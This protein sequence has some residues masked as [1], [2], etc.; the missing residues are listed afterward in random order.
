MELPYRTLVILKLHLNSNLNKNISTRRVKITFLIL[1]LLLLSPLLSYSESSADTETK[2]LDVGVI[3]PLTGD[4]SYWGSNPRK[5]LD[6]AIQDLE[7]GNKFK[8]KFHIE[9]DS[10]NARKAVSAFQKLTDIDK[11][12][13]VL[14]PVCSS[15][16]LAVAPLALIKDIPLIVFSEADSLSGLQNVFRLWAPNG[17]QAITLAKYA[18]RFNS[19][20]IL[21]VENAFGIDLANHVS[22]E[23]ERLGH[24]PVTYETYLPTNAGDLKTQLIKIRAKRPDALLFISYIQDGALLVKQAKNMGIAVPLLGPSTVNNNDFY[25]QL[26]PLANGIVLA[27]LPDSSSKEFRERWQKEFKEPWPGMQS[28]GSLFYD[29]VKI[30]ELAT[31]SGVETTKDWIDYLFKLKDFHGQSGKIE[32]DKIGDLKLEHVLFQ[33]EDGKAIVLNK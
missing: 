7:K 30:M 16:S 15:S 11:V 32:F 24:T 14:G 27:D 6:L 2:I 19:I 13:I 3:L 26:G 8:V 10:C 9:N 12:K 28:G 33:V 1:T 20:G 25:S 29:F 17:K 4:A 5:G 31:N 23:L 21:S 22:K 18:S